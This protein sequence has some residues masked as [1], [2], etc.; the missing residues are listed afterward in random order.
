MSVSKPIIDEE[1][2][3]EVTRKIEIGE[4]ELLTILRTTAESPPI[5][6][7]VNVGIENDTGFLPSVA[8]A[9]DEQ[10]GRVRTV[11]TLESAKMNNLRTNTD[12]GSI[13]TDFKIFMFVWSNDY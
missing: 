3:G 6:A 10:E 12:I 8:K 1:A 2:I 4:D 7:A 9:F 5:F 11:N 13:I